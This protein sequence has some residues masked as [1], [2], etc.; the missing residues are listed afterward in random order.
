[1]S[2]S[3]LVLD[4]GTGVV[5]AGFAGDEFP[6]CVFPNVTGE[7]KYPKCMAGA[8]E[9]IHVG[10]GVQRHRG[11][12]RLS[13]PME[14]GAIKDWDGMERVWSHIYSTLSIMSEEHNVLL[15]EAPFTTRQMKERAAEVF[16]ETF[17]AP[18]LCY[19]LQPVL[20]LYATGNNT[21]VVLS[22]GDGVTYSVP[23]YEG[24]SIPHAMGRVDL[25]GR[26][27]TE[28]LQLQLRK[29]GYHFTT[30]AE[31]EMLRQMKELTCYVA[32]APAM[33]EE[34][35][36]K[37]TFDVETHKLPDGTAIA[38]GPER[39]RAAD[40]LFNPAAIGSECDPIQEV[41]TNSIRKSDTDIRRDLYASIHLAGG[42][43][44][45]KGFGDRLVT[46]VRRLAPKDTKI[47]VR[48]PQERV[49]TTWLGGSILASLAAFKSV[50]VSKQKYREEGIKSLSAI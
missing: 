6:P 19:A 32:H 26:D 37:G 47:K 27:V 25:A 22:S 17:N 1:M 33:E 34:L 20:A 49:Y 14:H 48:A 39:F 36:R 31:F 8:L 50:C 12:L 15:T 30:S 18:A 29:S 9:G 43:T 10:E 28:H 16:F 35:A 46:E 38:L 41:L 5:K 42:S 4:V 21:G 2:A 45:L 3:H 23:I 7:A 40:V 13:Y 24:Y 44:L 11:L